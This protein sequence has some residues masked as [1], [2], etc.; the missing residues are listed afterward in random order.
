MLSLLLFLLYISHIY[1]A[2]NV[3]SLKTF[4]ADAVVSSLKTNVPGD[5][6]TNFA[7]QIAGKL[8]EDLLSDSTTRGGTQI[9]QPIK[10][11]QYI[12]QTSSNNGIAGYYENHTVQYSHITAST[13]TLDDTPLK[14]NLKLFNNWPPC[15][16]SQDNRY[17]WAF[18]ELMD[19]PSSPDSD[20][21]Y[22]HVFA[23][24]DIKTK[25]EKRFSLDFNVHKSLINHCTIAYN[26]KNRQ[27]LLF[28]SRYRSESAMFVFCSFDDDEPIIQA[29]DN[30]A[31]KGLAR[32]TKIQWQFIDDTIIAATPHAYFVYEPQTRDIIELTY[33]VTSQKGYYIHNSEQKVTP[34]FI[35]LKAKEAELGY[36]KFAYNAYPAS[37]IPN[38][39]EILNT[40][41]YTMVPPIHHS[42]KRTYLFFD[43]ANLRY[44]KSEY[45]P[46]VPSMQMVNVT[47]VL[48]QPLVSALEVINQKWSVD[49]KLTIPLYTNIV[50]DAWY[51]Y[52]AEKQTDQFLNLQE[53][54]PILAKISLELRQVYPLLT[55]SQKT[56]ALKKR[57]EKA[58]LMTAIP[59]AF[60][61][62]WKPVNATALLKGIRQNIGAWWGTK[63]KALYATLKRN[64]LTITGSIIGF[65][66]VSALLKIYPD[67]NPVLSLMKKLRPSAPNSVVK[68]TVG[69]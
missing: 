48:S 25:E 69:H 65:V 2:E 4:A 9:S 42:P 29:T 8:L 30:T 16:V 60:S 45:I 15:G 57:A 10:N 5:I 34:P 26:K 18:F 14:T 58:K 52:H 6:P 28:F 37:F 43:S 53:N 59:P 46:D 44:L 67:F 38:F 35:M 49:S 12:G 61:S 7:N 55:P 33:D 19:P 68:A 32:K 11:L 3:P 24:Q 1:T 47:N 36:K 50:Y 20:V 54:S 63:T 62:T 17:V 21:T 51:I 31:V 22:Q 39:Q 41:I 23:L 56:S 27:F 64:Q 13:L 40:K 66:V